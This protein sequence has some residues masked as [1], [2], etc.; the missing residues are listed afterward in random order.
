MPPVRKRSPRSTAAQARAGSVSHT[1]SPLA[2]TKSS[3][4][5]RGS[6]SRARALAN[7]AD[8]TAPRISKLTL[9]I[10]E[11]G[12]GPAIG[13]LVMAAV[14]L[15]SKAAARLKRLGVVDS[16]AFGAGVD[17]HARR[18]ELAALIKAQAAWWEVRVV[19]VGEIDA[20]VA[21][22]ELNLL[23]REVATTFI[24]AAPACDRIVADGA[25]M[26][27]PLAQRYAHLQARDGGESVHTAVAAASI[28]AKSERDI[29]F[30][31][32]A[33]RYQAEF[34]ELRGGGY[35]NEATRAFLCAYARK[36]RAVPPELR[37]S[38]P[39]PYLETLVD[40]EAARVARHATARQLRLL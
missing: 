13:P 10:D 35:V 33:Q 40:L 17:A 7:P 2:P 25:R 38:W 16:K 23:E 6:R 19:T 20:R 34:G 28:L 36:Y 9:G 21:N 29:Q 30:A 3:Q 39:H 14:L 15:E 1:A 5:G 22:G 8:R 37:L 18:C 27:A 24:D 11:A 4:P 31:S 26:F 12:R 32:I